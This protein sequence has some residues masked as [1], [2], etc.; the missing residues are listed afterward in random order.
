M[1]VE[2]LMHLTV[3]PSKP[4]EEIQACIAEISLAHGGAK[5][6]AILQEID[7]WLG[8]VV[9]GIEQKIAEAERVRK[10]SE[11]EASK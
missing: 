4:V 5:Q 1:K 11:T 9:A 7:L 2:H 8:G 3:D 6:L 10:E